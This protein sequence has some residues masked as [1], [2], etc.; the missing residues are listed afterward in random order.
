MQVGKLAGKRRSSWRLRECEECGCKATHRDVVAAW[1]ITAVGAACWAGQPRPKWLE[2]PQCAQ[3]RHG[4][5]R[6]G[7]GGGGGGG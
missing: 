2:R 6:G 3:P 1:N 7:R 5:G 4:R